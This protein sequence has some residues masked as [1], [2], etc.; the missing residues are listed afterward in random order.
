MNYL[1]IGLGSA[2]QRHLRVLHKFWGNKAK[3]YAYR[4]NHKRGL[5]SDGLDHENFSINPIEFYNA[6]EI[7]TINKI[8]KLIWDLVV[9]AT[10]PDSHHAYLQKVITNSKRILIEKPLTVRGAESSKI[11]ELAKHHNIPILTGYQ[12]VF[13]PFHKFIKDNL[14]YLGEIKSCSTVFREDLSSMNPFRSMENHYL[15]KPEGG[16]AFLSLSHDLDFILKIFEQSSADDI[17]FTETIFS[18]NG[19]LVECTLNSTIWTQ[20]KQI[21]LK[22]EFSILPG[23][24]LKTGKILG[25]DAGIY[26]D[27]IRGTVEVTQLNGKKMESMNYLS[28]KD[29]L[30]KCQIEK[31]LTLNTY[32]KYCQDNLNL[33]KFIVET[34][35]MI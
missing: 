3:I 16:G 18:I 20:S 11:I 31:I 23:Q 8:S 32:T 25:S 4:G 7:N 21:D 2:G 28:D 29:F 14:S 13:H 1:V 22:S 35:S 30:F 15:S 5:I 12:M 27:F 24:T 26:W 17:F 9:I 6:S 34:N 10:P 33:A 19:L